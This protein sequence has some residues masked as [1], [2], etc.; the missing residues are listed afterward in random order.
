MQSTLFIHGHSLLW[1]LHAQGW[2][3]CGLGAWATDGLSQ[4]LHGLKSA[5]PL[6]DR[7]SPFRGSLVLYKLMCIRGQHPVW[8]SNPT[9]DVAFCYQAWSA[10]RKGHTNMPR[11]VSQRGRTSIGLRRQMP[12]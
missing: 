9:A 3:G 8:A 7:Y 10:F 1:Q 11:P 12:C 6:R 2:G 4:N 5:L